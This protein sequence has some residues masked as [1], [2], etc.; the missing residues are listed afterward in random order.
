MDTP[1]L[2]LEGMNPTLEVI[3]IVIIKVSKKDLD[4]IT[5]ESGYDWLYDYQYMNGRMKP[6]KEFIAHAPEPSPWF[7]KFCW[8]LQ[9]KVATTTTIM[10]SPLD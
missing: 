2:T 3:S 9:Q 1:T 5:D 4:K 10:F 6:L 7:Q 8:D